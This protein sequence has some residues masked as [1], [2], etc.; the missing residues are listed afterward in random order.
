MEN[1]EERKSIPLLGEKLPG[2]TVHTTKINRPKDYEGKWIVIFSHPA[3]FTP[4]CATEFAAFAKRVKEFKK[5][6]A[7]LIGLSIDQVFSHIK[8]VELIYFV[9][10]PI[11]L[12]C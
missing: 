3:D 6:N 5:L 2:M 7:Q 12:F 10:V 11:P 8:W 1:N 4:V 9:S